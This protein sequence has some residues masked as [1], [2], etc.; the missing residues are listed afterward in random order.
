MKNKKNWEESINIRI[1][2]LDLTE[3]LSFISICN[4]LQESATKHAD[5]LNMSS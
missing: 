3:R 4:Y 2:D 5:K 1:Y